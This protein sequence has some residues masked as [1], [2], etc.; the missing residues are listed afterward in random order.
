MRRGRR[1]CVRMEEVNGLCYDKKGRGGWMK[2]GGTGIGR[3]GL[4]NRVTRT[5]VKRWE[6][7]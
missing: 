2:Q 6:V 4:N 5:G 3:S 1:E 7:F